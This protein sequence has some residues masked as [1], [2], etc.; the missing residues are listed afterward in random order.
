MPT[1]MEVSCHITTA[2]HACLP[3]P[4]PKI[5]TTPAFLLPLPRPKRRSASAAAMAVEQAGGKMVVELVGAFNVLTERM[6]LLSTASSRLLFKTLK[7]SLPLLHSLPFSPDDAR[8]PLSRAL[9]VASLLAHLQ[10]LS[11]TIIIIISCACT[12]FSLPLFPSMFNNLQ[13][14]L[15]LIQQA[16]TARAS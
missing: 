14:N 11:S 12:Q 2:A 3:Q 9:S 7:F 13:V 4:L 16:I 6:N 5:T 1:V 8:P 10:V 15:I